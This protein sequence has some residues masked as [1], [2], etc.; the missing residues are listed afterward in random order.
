MGQLNLQ[1]I[2]DVCM[3]LKQ[4]GENLADYQVY[5]GKDDELNG[6]HTGWYT[7]ILGTGGDSD[8]TFLGLIDEDCCNA[9]FKGKGILI[10]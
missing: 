3:Q 2:F 9:E 1:N 8:E 4:D 6:I 5:L 7:N 10:S